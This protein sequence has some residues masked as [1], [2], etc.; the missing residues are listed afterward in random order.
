VTVLSADADIHKIGRV[1]SVE[2]AVALIAGGGGTDFRPVFRWLEKEGRS[3]GVLVYV[4][5]GWGAYPDEPPRNVDVVW[6]M[7]GPGCKTPPWG[8]VVE[9]ALAA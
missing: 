3:H 4:T 2:K 1:N 9:V 8:K 5:D 7:T 6:V